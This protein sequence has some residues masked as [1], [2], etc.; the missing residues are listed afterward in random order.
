MSRQTWNLTKQSKQFYVLTYRK[1]GTALIVS[2]IINLFL[3]L[4]IY[5]TYFGRPDHEFYAT[6]GVT[7]PDRLIAM[8]A[9]NNSSAALLAPDPS[10]ANDNKVMPQ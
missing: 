9:P 2:V 1:A 5:Y 8:D 10:D 7:Y 6:N 4:G 3:S